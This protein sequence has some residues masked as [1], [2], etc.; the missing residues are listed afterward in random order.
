MEKFKYGNWIIK[1]WFQLATNSLLVVQFYKFMKLVQM[2]IVQV[3]A[4]IKNDFLFMLTFVKSK[5]QNLLVRHLNIVICMFVQDLFIND[6]L[7]FQAIISNWNDGDKK[8][9]IV[10]CFI[11]ITIMVV[12]F[13]GLCM[14]LKCKAKFNV[15]YP[16][17]DRLRWKSYFEIWM[18]SKKKMNS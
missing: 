15:I 8:K 12:I 4:G 1:L 11:C 10:K 17:Y 7:N 6:I 13:Y 14:N 18:S 5:L 2:A 3:V 9:I 16:C